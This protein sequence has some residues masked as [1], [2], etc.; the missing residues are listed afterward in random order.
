VVGA[1]TD[2]SGDELTA[3]ELDLARKYDLVRVSAKTGM[4]VHKSFIKVTEK[5]YERLKPVLSPNGARGTTSITNL[6]IRETKS[7]QKLS[8]C[9]A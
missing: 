2:L 5:I 1:K 3:Q 9:C 7:R 6:V 8:K 4:N